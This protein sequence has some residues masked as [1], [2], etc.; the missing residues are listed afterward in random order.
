M[1]EVRKALQAKADHEKAADE[2]LAA[3]RSW[4]ERDIIA[5]DYGVRI[6]RPR[7]RGPIGIPN[8]GRWLGS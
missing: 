1:D 7:R 3:A 2:A 8:N 6:G 5:A 4:V